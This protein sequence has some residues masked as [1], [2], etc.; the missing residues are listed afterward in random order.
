MDTRNLISKSQARVALLTLTSFLLTSS[1]WLL[2]LYHLMDL[3]TPESIDV[4]TMGIGY[5]MQ[6]VGTGAYAFQTYK[7][8]RPSSPWTLAIAVVVYTVSLLPATLAPNLAPTLAFGYLAN[9]LCGYLQGHYLYC[10][11]RY[12]DKSH[13]GIVFGS[14]YAISTVASWVMS[15]LA[16][17]MLVQGVFGLLTCGLLAAF[18]LITI[19]NPPSDASEGTAP[20][21]ALDYRAIALACTVVVLMSL[22]K[23]MGFSFPATDL[24]AGVSLELTRMLYGLGL[25]AAGYVS[26]RSR[27][28][29][30]LC[31]AGALVSPFL[32]LALEGAAA[33]S[34]LLWA[35]GYLLSGFFTVFRVLLLADIASDERIYAISCLGLVFGRLGDSLATILAAALKASPLAL[36]TV[37]AVL[38]SLSIVLFFVLFG[39]HYAPTPDATPSEQERF[40]R[41]AARHDLSARECEVLRLVLAERS[42]T[43]I[44]SELF[45]S[46]AT[47]KYHVRNLLRKTGCRRRLEIRAKYY[48]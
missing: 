1:G 24:H 36:I 14:A 10:L 2:W 7:S 32:M 11:A 4:L 39:Q 33:P 45:V 44:A 5:L 43:E 40:E 25:L 3:A 8:G 47:V 19:R 18:T 13:R 20:P 42:N 41:F 17:G 27:P 37:S 38:F 26:D 9:L 16:G 12:V 29:G 15:T 21:A 46:E 31:C 34:T 30:A 35:L 28:Y 22:T 23:G 6:A 48:E